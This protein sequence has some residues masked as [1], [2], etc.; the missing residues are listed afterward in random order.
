MKERRLTF[1]AVPK[2]ESLDLCD[3]SC[4]CMQM[5]SVEGMTPYTP[6]GRF[7]LSS[8]QILMEKVDTSNI[9]AYGY[10]LMQTETDSDDEP[11]KKPKRSRKMAKMATLSTV[12]AEATT[13]SEDEEEK[14]V[15]STTAGEYVKDREVYLK[16]R[17]RQ[18]AALGE[19]RT[20]VRMDFDMRMAKIMEACQAFEETTTTFLIQG[21]VSL[22]ALNIDAI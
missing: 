4:K 13:L 5:M 17:N 12:A 14:K 11:R 3:G 8:I 2:S 1:M 9:T 16:W 18:A 22:P 21:S 7:F 6:T 20:R 10:H 15:S 19:A